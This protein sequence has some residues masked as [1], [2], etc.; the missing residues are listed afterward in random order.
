V[1]RGAEPHRRPDQRFTDAAVTRR[2]SSQ[3]RRCRRGGPG[4]RRHHQAAAAPGHADDAPSPSPLRRCLRRV[5]RPPPSL[6]AARTLSG[7]L[8]A[9]EVSASATAANVFDT[10][11]LCCR[12]SP[13][14]GCNRT[15]PV[16]EIVRSPSAATIACSISIRSASRAATS[17]NWRSRAS[18]SRPSVA[19]C[20]SIAA[21]S[22]R[23]AG[24]YP[25][26]ALTAARR[27]RGADAAISFGSLPRSSF[28][29]VGEGLPAPVIEP[30]RRVRRLTVLR[31]QS[32]AGL[33]LTVVDLLVLDR[34]QVV[35]RGVQPA[36][37]VPGRPTRRSRA[38]RR[39]GP[40]MGRG[41][42]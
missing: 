13:I 42:G 19:S 34:R 30:P 18:G 26:R 29:P 27:P 6:R 25:S 14:A 9:P 36:V 22:S 31:L 16:A 8:R 24:P 41:G 20:A 37:V 2:E 35:A 40:S 4:A 1:S 17:S 12:S 21:T 38:R 15:T 23:P 33:V 10:A 5:M 3:G 39:R 11:M 32:I 7:S 28:C